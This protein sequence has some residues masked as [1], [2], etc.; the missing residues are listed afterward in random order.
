MWV[1]G[2]CTE[3]CTPCSLNNAQIK[4]MN[5]WLAEGL[6]QTVTRIKYHECGDDCS[7]RLEKI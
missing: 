1:S 3:T 7:C 4:P 6:P 2:K 5:I